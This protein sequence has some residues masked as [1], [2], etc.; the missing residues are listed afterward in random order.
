MTSDISKTITRLLSDH[1]GCLDLQRLEQLLHRRRAD[2]FTASELRSALLDDGLLAIRE[3]KRPAGRGQQLSPDSLLV[4][5]TPLRLCQKKSG[6]CARCERLHLCKYFVSGNCSFG[7]TCKNSHSLASPHNAAVLQ[8]FGLEELGQKQLFQLLLQNDPFLLPEVCFHYNVGDG[9]FGNCKFTTSCTKLHICR[10]HLQGDCR[11]GSSCKKA[12]VLDQHGRKLIQGL[13]PEN[14]TNLHK[15]Y[16]NKFIIMNQHDV[17]VPAPAMKNLSLSESAHKPPQARPDPPST[18]AGPPKAAVDAEGNEICLFFLRSHCSFK[19][20]CARVHWHLPYRWQ[21]LDG[22]GVTWKDLE[23]TEEVEKAYC[24][25]ARDTSREDR[26]SRRQKSFG[27]EQHVDFQ[28]MTFG[29]SP[30]RRLSTAS[31]VSKPP[32]FILTTQWLWYWRDESGAWQEYGKGVGGAGI[33]SQ[34]LEK[35]YLADRETGVPFTATNFQY[36]VHFKDEKGMYQQNLKT[37]TKREVRRRPRFVSARDVETQL[38]SGSSNT[39]CSSTAENL[40]SHWDKNALPDFGFKLVTLSRS[41]PDYVNIEKLFRTTMPASTVNSIQRIQNPSLWR[42]F[43]WQKEQMQGKN[44]GKLVD[45]RYLFHGT[46]EALIEAICEQNF[47]WRVCGVHGTAYGKGSYFARD[48]SLSNKFSK[49]RL[50]SNKVM[51]VALVLVGDYTE[52]Q[53]SYVRPPVKRG[54]RDL[55]DSCVDSESNPSIFVVFEKQQIYPEYIIKYV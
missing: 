37:K 14:A 19:E 35:M 29:G 44:G 17:S 11:F 1:H 7:H 25:P 6:A 16:M 46:E 5:K 27:S 39:S 32:H 10:H 45:Q 36:V 49:P 12:H 30:V 42:V 8:R 21:L 31:C 3:G 18:S 51:F 2:S 38:S 26:A 43:Q 22:D 24:D 48:A 52:G 40:P 55:Y 53:S 13:S 33:T 28:T 20:K 54:S 41:A 15:I 50:G 23:N 4:L 9:P 34:T 47:D